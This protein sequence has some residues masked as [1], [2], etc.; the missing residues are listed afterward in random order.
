M[1]LEYDDVEITNANT[2]FGSMANIKTMLKI[3]ED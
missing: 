2:R 1:T 3:K